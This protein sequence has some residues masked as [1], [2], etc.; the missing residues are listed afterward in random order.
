M[1]L[2]AAP[3]AAT[4][5]LAGCG[6]DTTRTDDAPAPAASSSAPVS[7]SAAGSPGTPAAPEPKGVVVDVTVE[8]ESIEPNGERVEAELGEP[9][10]LHVTS[11][12]AGELH[13]HSTPEQEVEFD[14]GETRIELSFD[15][16]GIVE[17]ED[18]ESGLVVVQL[19]V[20]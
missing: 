10:I 13:V 5:L 9:V 2:L 18:H 6:E 19:Q 8:G 12:R 16:P 17:V 1:V 11:D 14:E 3:L 20:S 7:P 15:Q 4:L